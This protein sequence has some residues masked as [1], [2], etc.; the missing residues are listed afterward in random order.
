MYRKPCRRTY[1]L[2]LSPTMSRSKLQ[3]S[4]SFNSGR[5][6]DEVPNKYFRKFMLIC[7]MYAKEDIESVKSTG[8]TLLKL[9]HM[10][11]TAV[12]SPAP[13]YVASVYTFRC[14]G[15]YL[16]TVFQHHLLTFREI[17][18]FPSHFI[19]GALLLSPSVCF[20]NGLILYFVRSCCHNRQNIEV[21]FLSL[22]VTPT[23]SRGRKGF[24]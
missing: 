1:R 19:S 5:F 6:L 11:R 17:T 2:A 14:Y 13:S 15:V 10:I 23:C 8:K 3:G 16:Q 12:P 9:T 20:L 4:A 18:K 22:S 24:W 7:A 21:Y